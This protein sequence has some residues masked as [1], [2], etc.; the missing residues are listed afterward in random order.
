MTC[1]P[2]RDARGELLAFGLHAAAG[3]AQFGNG[4][5]LHGAGGEAIPFAEGAGAAG[6][7]VRQR[8]FGRAASIADSENEKTHDAY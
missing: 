4:D 2:L 6:E 5:F 7:I 1:A 8:A 3:L